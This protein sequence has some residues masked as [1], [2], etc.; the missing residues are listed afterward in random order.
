[1]LRLFHQILFCFMGLSVI[2]HAAEP[3]TTAA[4]IRGLTREEAAEKRP[5][6]I[7]GVVTFRQPSNSR[8]SKRF[9]FVV[10]D[11][12]VGIYVNGTMDPDDTVIKPL[13]V[14]TAPETGSLVEVRGVTGPGGFAPI[15]IASEIRQIGT[16][17][18]PPPHRVS[19][20]ELRTGIFD[21]QRVEVKGVVRR[22]HFNK[23]QGILRLDI[24]AEDE[25][26]SIFIYDVTGI[27]R[28]NL[29]DAGVRVR[30]VCFM[31]FNRR[32][33]SQGI[34]IQGWDRSDLDVLKPANPDPFAAP[35]AN[36]LALKPFGLTP[37]SPHRHRLMG[38]VTLS[39]PGELLYVETEERAF[40]VETRSKEKFTVGDVVE[41]SGFVQ[42]TDS[43]AKLTESVV[44]K[45]G[46]GKVPPPIPVSLEKVLD[47]GGSQT[48]NLKLE[49]YDGR[50]VQMDG[51]LI[52]VETDAQGNHLIY[53][54]CEGELT[55]ATLGKGNGAESLSR[56][57]LG[58]M[59]R[60]TGICSVKLNVEWP[61]IA[62]P[63]ASGLSLLLRDDRDIIVL[64]NPPWWTPRR[65]AW[66]LGGTAFILLFLAV[67]N[68]TLRRRVASQTALIGDK[69]AN[70]TRM[71]ERHRIGREL[72]DTILQEITGI[73][74]LINNCKR[75]LHE[76]E[77]ALATLNM[78]ERMVQHC[79]EESRSTIQDLMSASLDS[80]GL[81]VAVEELVRPLAEMN[82]ATFEAEYVGG[83]SHIRGRLGTGLLRI[84]HEA[85]ANAGKSSGATKIRLKAEHV[86]DGLRLTISDN[87][88]GF[89]VAEARADRIR[90]FGLMGMEENALK[91]RGRLEIESTPGSGTIVTVTVPY[92]CST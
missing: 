42:M 52:K 5:A 20:A 28:T 15:L 41:A 16:A 62:L 83:F 46:T 85:A 71:E 51:R 27:D 92:P 37:P 74:M 40:R 34:Y 88:R 9:S 24:A 4:R 50:L 84:A 63:T 90:H 43:F 72:H 31:L 91:F 1:M 73:G 78:A 70:E 89:N 57:V 33:E 82:G 12:T 29:V 86:R 59:L 32:G 18:L 23:N 61:A 22:V 8:Y 25:V 44:R 79:S 7:R 11:E 30:G 53:L 75:R 64:T 68:M 66:A 14:G 55:L 19:L 13:T 2:S 60:L 69:V 81:P 6:M 39:R 36:P 45:T 49:D 87:G 10:Q 76:P 77:T 56:I 3:L 48:M 35:L 47:T 26:F 21:C 67:W 17:L 58:S 38:V 65:M 54:D 80:G